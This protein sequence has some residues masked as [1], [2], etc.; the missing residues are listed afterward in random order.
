VFGYDNLRTDTGAGVRL[1]TTDT[2]KFAKVAHEVF[3]TLGVD[4]PKDIRRDLRRA[5]RNGHAFGSDED[6][7]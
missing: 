4:P 5:I 2:G 1:S 7:Q 6:V 3:E